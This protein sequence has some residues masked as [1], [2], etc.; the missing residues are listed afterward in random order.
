MKQR[1]DHELKA[2]LYDEFSDYVSNKVRSDEN[3]HVTLREFENL[4]PAG[5]EHLQIPLENVTNYD[6]DFIRRVEAFKTGT[7]VKS[8]ENYKDG[9]KIPIAFVPFKRNT[10]YSHS[11]SSKSSSKPP[12][13]TTLM[14]YLVA[15]FSTVIVGLIK[16]TS[17]DW[18]YFLK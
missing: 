1:K 5:A 3:L 4:P 2:A 16:T 7:K 6:G 12:S 8:K 9:T 14:L 18:Q 11:S 15:L 13:Q 10:T 17:A